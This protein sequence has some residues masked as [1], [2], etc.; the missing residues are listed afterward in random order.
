M[1]GRE[2]AAPLSPSPV[3]T[4]ARAFPVLVLVLPTLNSPFLLVTWNFGTI[5]P[6]SDEGR[7]KQQISTFSVKLNQVLLIHGVCMCVCV[8]LCMCVCVLF[9][10]C[11]CVSCSPYVCVCLVLTSWQLLVLSLLY[12]MTSWRTV[13]ANRRCYNRYNRLIEHLL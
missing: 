8:V 12:Y 5:P 6:W 7:K 9:P 11:V 1:P 2:T 4:H 3:K 13:R 10:T